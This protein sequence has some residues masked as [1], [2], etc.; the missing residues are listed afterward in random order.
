MSNTIKENGVT[1]TLDT[2]ESEKDLN[3]GVFVDPLLSS[4]FDLLLKKT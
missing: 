4:I 3:L 1:K 2:T